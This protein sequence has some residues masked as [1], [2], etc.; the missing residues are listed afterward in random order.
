MSWIRWSLVI[1]SAREEDRGKCGTHPEEG[2]PS[3][4]EPLRFVHHKRKV[5]YNKKCRASWIMAGAI[6]GW[7]IQTAGVWDHNNPHAPVS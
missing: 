7:D 6:T 1:S 2:I 5:G 4:N 3:V